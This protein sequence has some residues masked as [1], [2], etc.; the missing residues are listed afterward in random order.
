MEN[1]EKPSTV[2][3]IELAQKV[4]S[5]A[6]MKF[7]LNLSDAKIAEAF[8]VS[9]YTVADWKRRPEWTESIKAIAKN[10]LTDT[11]NELYAMAPYAR[12]VIQELMRDGPPAIRLKAAQAI[13]DALVKR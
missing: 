2:K 10:Q 4:R 9:P 8:N 3:G 13:C 12:Q 7:L 11:Y 5:A 1:P 6:E